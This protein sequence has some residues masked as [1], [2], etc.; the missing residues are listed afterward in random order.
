VNDRNK[1]DIWRSLVNLDSKGFKAQSYGQIRFR[2]TIQTVGVG[3]SILKELRYTTAGDF[4]RRTQNMEPDVP[5]ITTLQNECHQ[6]ILGLCVTMDP[7]RRDLMLC[8][9]ETSTFEHPKI[10][11]YENFESKSRKSIKTE[12]SSK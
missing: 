5:Y 8:V 10:P 4:T 2:G 1:L 7:G 9:H 12:T 6:S 11:L 3:I